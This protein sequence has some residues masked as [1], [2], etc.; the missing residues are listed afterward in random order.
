MKPTA[1]TRL[2]IM[3]L[4]GASA[5]ALVSATAHAGYYEYGGYVGGF[6]Q[7]IHSDNAP[8]GKITGN[9]AATQRET[10]P[11]DRSLS[12]RTAQCRAT[13]A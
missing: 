3:A 13:H 9:P 7:I 2:L 6:G 1:L 12:T 10:K 8:P 11:E 4:S 5:V